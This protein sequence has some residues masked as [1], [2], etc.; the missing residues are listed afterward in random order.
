[1]F[2]IGQF[3]DSIKKYK[4]VVICISFVMIFMSNASGAHGWSILTKEINA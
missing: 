2:N 1:M 4:I 3:V